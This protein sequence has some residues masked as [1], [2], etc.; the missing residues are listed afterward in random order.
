MGVV[1]TILGGLRSGLEGVESDGMVRAFMLL[2]AFRS[3]L[4][5][6]LEDFAVA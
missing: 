3:R 4:R 6:D 5:F 1:I 2:L